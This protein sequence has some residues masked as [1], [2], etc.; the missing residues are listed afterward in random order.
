MQSMQRSTNLE[1]GISAAVSIKQKEF[2]MIGTL[3]AKT[4]ELRLPQA[5]NLDVITAVLQ[6]YGKLLIL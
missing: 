5:I 6:S 3:A 4:T 1:L 2:K